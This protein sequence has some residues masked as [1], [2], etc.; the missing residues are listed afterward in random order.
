M[1]EC[2]IWYKKQNLVPLAQFTEHIFSINQKYVQALLE[3]EGAEMTR[4]L[5]EE[6]AHFYVCGD[7][8]MA[9]DV[10]Q[11]LEKIIEKHGDM[12]EEDAKEFVAVLRVIIVLIIHQRIC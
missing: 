1:C 4:L 10:E 11:K 3:D 2:T 9:N 5:V 6:N 12:T 8:T 7:C